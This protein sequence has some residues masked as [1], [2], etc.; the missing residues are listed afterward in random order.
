MFTLEALITLV[1]PRPYS[2]SSGAS[3]FR[4]TDTATE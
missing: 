2:I 4:N 1:E 3:Y